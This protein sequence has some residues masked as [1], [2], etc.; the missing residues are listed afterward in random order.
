MAST[1]LEALEAEVK[2]QL[3][4]LAS[5]QL[6]EICIL[7]KITEGTE[8]KSHHSLIKHITRYLDSE[9]VEA[10]TDNG[11]AI[12][13]DV[14][15]VMSSF[16]APPPQS[17]STDLPPPATSHPPLDLKATLDL[18]SATTR[19]EFKIQGQVGKPGQTD[20]LT[21]ASLAR[22]IEEGIRRGYA[23]DDI[24]SAVIRSI[25]YGL[26][27]R[28]F[29]EGR[30]DLTLPRLRS[31][32]RS[33]FN[34][35]DALSSYQELSTTAQRAKETPQEFMIRLM[36]LRQRILFTS[37]EDDAPVRYDES[38]IK[39]TFILALQTGIEEELRADMKLYLDDVHVTDEKLLEALNR[40]VNMKEK[41]IAQRSKVKVNEVHVMESQTAKEIT[42]LT[43]GLADLKACIMAMQQQRDRPTSRQQGARPRGCQLCRDKGT[44]DS[45]SHCFRCGGYD[46][47]ARGCKVPRSAKDSPASGNDPRAHQGDGM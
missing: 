36:N 12:L 6:Q 19:K 5:D 24:I 31:L 35:K 45:C 15:T 20:K 8:G 42:A 38:V 7:L 28:E 21:F 3:Y 41:R 43:A 34:E 32:L 46:H 1:D 30:T 11:T 14:L 39:N 22:Q 44:G 23:G 33:H 10:L 4:Q 29:L 2:T 18:L 13:K 40:A 9:E 16:K 17:T 37:Q 25:T 27:L 26:P 47:Y